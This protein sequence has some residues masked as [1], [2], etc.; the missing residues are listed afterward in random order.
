MLVEGGGDLVGCVSAVPSNLD[1]NDYYALI[2]HQNPNVVSVVLKFV[3]HPARSGNAYPCY[4]HFT[5]YR[6]TFM[7]VS[8]ATFYGRYN[9]R[10]AE[11]RKNFISSGSRIRFI[12]MSNFF[13]IEFC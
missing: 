9:E 13:P 5:F 1:S 4:L 6:W 11:V 3:C 8:G 7:Y 2:R 10:A 12:A